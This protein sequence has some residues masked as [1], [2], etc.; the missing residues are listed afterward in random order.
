M[1]KYMKQLVLFFILFGFIFIGC[2]DSDEP[3][4][5]KTPDSLVGTKWESA[6]DVI[7][8]DSI[9]STYLQCVKKTI[10]YFETEIEV[11]ISD[12]IIEP[13]NA[14]KDTTIS[15]YNYSYTKPDIIIEDSVSRE[16]QINVN[17]MVLHGIGCDD[18][19]CSG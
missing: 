2:S 5:T 19:T 10:M 6:Y 7:L 11:E 18:T 13:V 8:Y 12:F 14:N 4:F 1:Q 15:N 9:K 3:N 17:K 16:G